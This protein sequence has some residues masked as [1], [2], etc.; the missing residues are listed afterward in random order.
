MKSLWTDT[1]KL[2]H[3]P[4]LQGNV[5]TDVLIIGG[6]LSGIL[7]AYFLQKKRVNYILAEGDTIGVGITKNTTAKITSQHGLLYD[8]LLKHAGLE[9]AGMYLR[10]NEQAIESFRELSQ[11]YPCSFEEKDAYVYSRTDR[12]KIE[13][14]IEAVQALGFRAQFQKELPIPVTVKGAVKFEH[15][16]QFHPMQFIQGISPRD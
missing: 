15:Q 6:G 12:E 2:D 8:K 3:F 16:A 1:V 4:P 10:A 5:T 13:Q 9:R 7:C 11:S 14:E